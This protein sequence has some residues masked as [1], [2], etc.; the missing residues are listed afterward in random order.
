MVMIIHY[1]RQSH[2]FN[3]EVKCIY[4]LPT[5]NGEYILW[6][7][8]T[9]YPNQLASGDRSHNEKCKVCMST[10]EVHDILLHKI[11]FKQMNCTFRP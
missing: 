11:Q 6:L 1:Y 9:T 3:S 5:V 10:R 8:S 7:I 4:S 2:Q